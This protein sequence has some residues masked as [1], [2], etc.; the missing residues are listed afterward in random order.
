MLTVKT[1]EEVLNAWE[2]VVDD[3]I[4][5][6]QNRFKTYCSFN[7][8]LPDFIVSQLQERGYKVSIEVNDTYIDWAPNK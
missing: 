3:E 5:K 6:A 7:C 8:V 4:T 1:A 2:K